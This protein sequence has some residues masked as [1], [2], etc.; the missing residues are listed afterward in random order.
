MYSPCDSNRWWHGEWFYIR[1]PEE[2]FP[3]FTD[4]RPE[5]RESWSWGP[6][7]WQ[8]KLEIIGEELQK[9]VQHGLDGLRVFHTFFHHRVTPLLES[10]LPMW[11]Y[12]GPTDPDHAT[13]VEL[14]KDEV[15]SR[16]DRVLQLKALE[17]LEG[18]PRPFHAG[19]LPNLVRS[20]LLILCPFRFH[21]PII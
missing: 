5:R 1:N 15:W 17:A 6:S 10:K 8:N 7:S 9:L 11:L 20:P 21:S 12:S 2:P 18:K 14:A 19:K 3:P 13:P 4:R 16:L